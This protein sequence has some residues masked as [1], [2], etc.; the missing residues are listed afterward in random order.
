MVCLSLSTKLG[1]S[2]VSTGAQVVGAGKVSVGMHA[3]VGCADTMIVGGL[4][5]KVKIGPEVWVG[6]GG[7]SE[8][9]GPGVG[10]IVV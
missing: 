4:V 10:D 2:Q 1:L 8:N 6:R 7:H 5:G 9:T 3:V